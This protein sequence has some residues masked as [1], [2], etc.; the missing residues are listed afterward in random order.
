[1]PQSVASALKRIDRNGMTNSTLQP[2]SKLAARTFQRPFQLLLGCSLVTCQ[3]NM[4]PREFA[5]KPKALRPSWNVSNSTP[6]WSLLYMLLASR[7][8]SLVTR[9]AESVSHSRAET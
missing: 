8:M 6:K 5:L 2:P 7:R 4:P 9:R 1:M 3:S